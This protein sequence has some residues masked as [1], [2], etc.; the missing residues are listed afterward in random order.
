[1]HRARIILVAVCLACSVGCA[2]RTPH[3]LMRIWC[4]KNT[5]GQHAIFLETVDHLPLR[6]SRIDHYRWMYGYDPGTSFVGKDQ[7]ILHMQ[8]N[9]N[10]FPIGASSS[11][12]RVIVPAPAPSA[13]ND[14]PGLVPAPPPSPGIETLP[15]APSVIPKTPKTPVPPPQLPAPANPVRRPIMGPSASGSR[16][17]QPATFQQSANRAATVPA[18]TRRRFR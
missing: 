1:M 14:K 15:P 7:T 3:S 2:F 9:R 4:D 18:T 8:G 5:L 16:R 13:S 11:P 12:T 17:V 6:A 10:G